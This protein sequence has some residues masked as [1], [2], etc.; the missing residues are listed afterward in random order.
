M[1]SSWRWA[2]DEAMNRAN[3]WHSGALVM[4]RGIALQAMP[5]LQRRNGCLQVTFPCSHL[6]PTLEVS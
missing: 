6:L 2:M 3:T 5:V 1:K 4:T